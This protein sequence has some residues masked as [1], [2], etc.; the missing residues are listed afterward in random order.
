MFSGEPVNERNHSASLLFLSS[1]RIE[2]LRPA[3]C[4][5]AG[6]PDLPNTGSPRLYL[7]DRRQVQ[8]WNVVSV[9]SND[10]VGPLRKMPRHV[11]PDR[12][13]T[14]PNRWANRHTNVFRPTAARPQSVNRSSQNIRRRPAPSGM[15][16]RHYPVFRI[17]QQ[18]RHAIGSF[19]PDRHA[20]FRRNNRVAL[21]EPFPFS[22]A[23]VEY[24]RRVHLLHSCEVVRIRRSAQPKTMDQPGEIKIR[25]SDIDTLQSK[26]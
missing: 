4:A 5:F 3:K 22:P 25:R 19:Y 2:S 20:R 12:V 15:D 16:A 9:V 26:A 8:F 23:R 14:R 18:N 7:I 10:A 21:A 13:A 17:R 24:S 11:F 6:L 1:E